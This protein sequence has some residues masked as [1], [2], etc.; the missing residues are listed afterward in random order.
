MPLHNWEQLGSIQ[1]LPSDLLCND[2]SGHRFLITSHYTQ[3]L[4]HNS[5]VS[6]WLP[7]NLMVLVMTTHWTNFLIQTTV[8]VPHCCLSTEVAWLPF[9]IVLYS[10]NDQWTNGVANCLSRTHCAGASD[11]SEHCCL[12]LALL[13]KLTQ[14]L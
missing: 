5:K 13:G 12:T 6:P 8:I 9:T 4:A 3:H 2:V 10:C 7:G 14:G 11:Q 1:S